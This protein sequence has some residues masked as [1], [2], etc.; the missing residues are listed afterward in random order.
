MHVA[1]FMI[2]DLMMMKKLRHRKEEGSYR[3][4]FLGY[5]SFFLGDARI[6]LAT[7]PR[8]RPLLCMTEIMHVL[9][10]EVAV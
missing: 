5:Q 6:S 10:R 4:H 7:K 1:D 9:G 2:G 8:P 3:D